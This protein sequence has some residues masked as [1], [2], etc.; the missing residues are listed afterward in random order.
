[1]DSKVQ[2]PSQ[3]TK[4]VFGFFNS[5]YLGYTPENCLSLLEQLG[6][7]SEVQ[8]KAKEKSKLNRHS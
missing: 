6:L 1:M 5:H 2:K 8:K 3:S 4:K 7:I